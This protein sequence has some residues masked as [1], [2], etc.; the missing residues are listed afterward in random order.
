MKIVISSGH[1]LKVRG[2][3]GYLDE[4][5]EA[6]RVVEQIAEFMRAGGVEVKTFHDDTS[7]SQNQN[8]NTIV[9]YH[10]AQVRDL[11]V[12]VHFNA[13]QKTSNPMGTEVLYLTQESLAAKVSAAISDAGSFVNRGA[14]YR[15][16][17]FFL[18]S[19]EMPAILIEVC[20]VDSSADAGLY[21]QRFDSICEAVAN[22]AIADEPL[23]PDVS[24]P[25]EVPGTLQTD[26]ICT[27]FGGSSDPNNSA[28]SPYE[29]IDDSVLGVALPW[30]FKG[31][32]PL[33]KVMNGDRDV[34]CEIVDVGPWLIDD[35][36]WAHGQRPEAESCYYSGKPLDHG[37]NEGVVPNGAG[38]DVTPAAARELGFEGKTK[39]DWMFVEEGVA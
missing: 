36:Y 28:Y 5:D 17:L 21:E 39:V 33:V 32:R 3:S 10:N 2:A 31:P 27:T 29:F 25:L 24:E 35:D 7:T 26:I 11:D 6:R 9:N 37:P 38:I 13:Y 15:G 18:N 20:F 34:V 4:V 30:K 8:L 23:E 14:K 16:D 22:L 12:S 1:G 19:T